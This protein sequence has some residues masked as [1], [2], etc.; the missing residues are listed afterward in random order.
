MQFSLFRESVQ[1]VIIFRYYHIS[2]WSWFSRACD[3]NEILTGWA[4]IW[5]TIHSQTSTGCRSQRLRR[6]LNIP[7]LQN[8]D[9]EER[10]G[11]QH[12]KSRRFRG[13]ISTDGLSTIGH[14]K[15]RID[16][17]LF[18]PSKSFSTLFRAPFSQPF[19][20]HG[21]IATHPKHLLRQLF[22]L[23]LFLIVCDFVEWHKGL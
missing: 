18:C 19:L 23:P 8:R 20:S 16:F 12:R 13:S 17:A 7:S 14:C 3:E 9:N 21:N 15:L 4:A 22:S 1:T 5:T 6:S 10:G 11:G 2:F